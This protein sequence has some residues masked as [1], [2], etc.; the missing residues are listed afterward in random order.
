MTH[1]VHDTVSFDAL[2]HELVD[3]LFMK[4]GVVVDIPE[5]FNFSVAIVTDKEIQPMNKQYRGKDYPTDV[6][7]FRYDEYSGEIVLSADR[8]RAQAEEFGHTPTV[9]A[10]FMLVHGIL[11]IMG[12]DHERSE[13]EAKEMRQL[14]HQILR[15]C[16]L[17]FAR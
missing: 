3:T 5:Q 1:E 4:A 14:E 9:E 7:S 15:Q 17:A 13:K 6:L 11:H 12:W 10:A 16:G 2:P 8:I